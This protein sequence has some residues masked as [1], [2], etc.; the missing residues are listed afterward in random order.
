MLPCQFHP[1]ASFR[2]LNHQRLSVVMVQR[3]QCQSSTRHQ[4]PSASQHYRFKRRKQSLKSRHLQHRWFPIY[5]TRSLCRSSS[6][7]RFPTTRQATTTPP[8]PSTNLR[9]SIVPSTWTASATSSSHPSSTPTFKTY[10]TECFYMLKV[11][12]TLLKYS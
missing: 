4:L 6:A 10:N 8:G 12:L 3:A 11:I 9:I 5:R 1:A 7:H 2:R